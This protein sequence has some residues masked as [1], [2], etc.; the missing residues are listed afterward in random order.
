MKR[1]AIRARWLWG[2]VAMM[3]GS[4]FA[5]STPVNDQRLTSLFFGTV[6]YRQRENF[7]NDGFVLGQAVAQF[8]FEID[9]HLSAFTEMTAT[10]KQDEGF[11]FEI[12]RLFV[13]YDFSDH[14]KLSGGRYHTPL[15]YWNS[16]FHHGSWLQTTVSR[17]ETVKFGSNVIPIHFLGLL[18]EGNLGQTN[19]NYKLGYGN[20]RSEDI[21]DP[22]DLGD[23]NDS[24]AFLGALN[25]RLPGRNRLTT[26]LSLYIDQVEPEL[27]P[28]IDEQIATAYV[29]LEGESP[30]VIVEYQTPTLV[31]TGGTLPMTGKEIIAQI[32][33][34]G[35][36][37]R[38][39]SLQPPIPGCPTC[40]PI[41]SHTF[42]SKVT[43]TNCTR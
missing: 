34:R 20:G 40:P 13:R 22:G 8:N 7:D 17:P 10:A 30:E 41:A 29:V 32:E 1:L 43:A 5:E 11:E 24:G 2:F 6:D 4:A 12:E 33:F 31:S 3:A 19:F 42:A 15:G 35:G 9:S 27:E 28:K 14:F 21:H 26:G 16:A 38:S 25:Y 18:L 37:G 39:V 23:V 36:C